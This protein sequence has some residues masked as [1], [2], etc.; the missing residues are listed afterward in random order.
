MKTMDEI[1]ESMLDSYTEKTGVRPTVSCDMSLRLYAV[2]SQIFALHV[3]GEWLERQSFPQTA[4]GQY[5]EYH[6]ELRGV[7][8]KEAACAQGELLFSC[9]SVQSQPLTIPEGTVA[10][11]AGLIRVQTVEEGVIPSGATSTMVKAE[12]IDSGVGGNISADSIISMA[13]PPVGISLCSNP[14]TFENGTEEEGDESFRERILETFKRLPNGANAA[15]YVQEALSFERVSAATVIPR[16]RGICTVDVIISS[17][18][19]IPDDDLIAEVQA[20]LEEKREI[21]VDVLVKAPTLVYL[22]L[23][24]AL[25]PEEDYTLDEAIVQVTE[26]ITGW[27]DGNKLGV[28]LLEGELG[29]LIYQCST[30]LNYQILTDLSQIILAQDE[31]PQLGILTVKEL[32]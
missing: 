5:L 27:F 17:A 3:Q 7:S 16:S 19:G 26:A 21:A 6:G 18:S 24:L 2:A 23:E 13:V 30:V 29:N 15:F 8:R 31:M 22:D 12:A 25:T 32:P 14:E 9:N 10:M 1:Y 28:R 4:S 20:D 11:T